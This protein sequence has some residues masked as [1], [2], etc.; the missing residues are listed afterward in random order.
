MNRLKTEINEAA[1]TELQ[2]LIVSKF[3]S[4]FLNQNNRYV[5]TEDDLQ[6]V[7]DCINSFV[8]KDKLP[9]IKL[10]VVDMMPNDTGKAVFMFD[11]ISHSLP[12]KIKYLRDAECDTPLSMSSALSHEMIHFYD[13]LYGQIKFLK[14]KTVESKDRI[15]LI[16]NYDV[17]GDFFQKWMNV[18]VA[19]GIPSSVA[20]PGKVKVRYF[21]DN[22]ELKENEKPL[23]IAQKA[24]MFYDAIETDDLFLV[25]VKDEHVYCVM[26]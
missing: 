5:A 24:K 12:P 6:I 9:K 25:E 15:Q 17:H 18:I 13:Y 26:Q 16:G 19:N 21:M 7:Y 10:E 8:F 23:T 11:A 14:G 3:G 22:E 2:R 4:R 20:H 1:K